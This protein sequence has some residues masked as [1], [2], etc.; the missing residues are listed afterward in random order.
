MK[1]IPWCQK[2]LWVFVSHNSTKSSASG[3]HATAMWQPRV[4]HTSHLNIHLIIWD[5]TG[6]NHLLLMF[7]MLVYY[8][9]VACKSFTMFQLHTFIFNAVIVMDFYSGLVYFPIDLSHV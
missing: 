3:L 4:S 5:F 1:N 7:G 6:A 9:R 2:R 8:A